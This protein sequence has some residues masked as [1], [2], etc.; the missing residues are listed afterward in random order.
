MYRLDVDVARFFFS[1]QTT[2]SALS[3]ILNKWMLLIMG[4]DKVTS[5]SRIKATTGQDD[6][7]RWSSLDTR[8]RPR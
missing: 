3:V 6:S 4:T 1:N 7:K 5:K 8:L 2:H